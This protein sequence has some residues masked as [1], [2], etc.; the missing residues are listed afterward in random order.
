MVDRNHYVN[1]RR[2]EIFWDQG[3]K[4]SYFVRGVLCPLKSAPKDTCPLLSSV[5]KLPF[6][7]YDFIGYF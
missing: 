5:S 1:T 6:Y 7:M 3:Q 2:T 4:P